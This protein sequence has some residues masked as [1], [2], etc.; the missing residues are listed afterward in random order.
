MLRVKF[1]NARHIG[2]ALDEPVKFWTQESWK[3]GAEKLGF[4]KFW[5]LESA[6]ENLNFWKFY[7]IIE[8]AYYRAGAQVN[9][10]TESEFEIF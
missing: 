8:V 10:K 1:Y 3:A 6:P 9:P 5:E 4:G 2:R 7:D